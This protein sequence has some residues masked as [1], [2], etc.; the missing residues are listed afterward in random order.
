MDARVVEGVLRLIGSGHPTAVAA[1]SPM[2]GE[3]GGEQL[4]GALLSVLPG[5]WLP[6]SGP[7]GRLG[8]SCCGSPRDL[9]RG[10][11]GILEPA[12]PEVDA[13]PGDVELLLCPALACS[14]DGVRLG[15]GAG[16]FDRALA[17][18]N[19]D[20]CRIIALTYDSELLERLPAEE[21]DA[22]VDGVLTPERFHTCVWPKADPGTSDDPGLSEGYETSPQNKA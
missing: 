17:G 5:V 22:P 19:R 7:D 18:V 16:Y 6:V 10:R 9:R 12:G 21:H 13:V 3:P 11:F 20:R 1:Y 14:V 4:V 15:R 2:P 8:W